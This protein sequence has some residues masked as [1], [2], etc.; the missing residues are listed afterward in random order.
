[1]RTILLVDDDKLHLLSLS[2]T[3]K[4]YYEKFNI[5]TAENG[6]EAERIL[7]SR[8]V[9]LLITDLNMPV[10]NG[11]ELLKFMVKKHS[12]I[13]VIVITASDDKSCR[14]VRSLSTNVKY[15]FS[16]PFDY[17]RLLELIDEHI[18]DVAKENIGKNYEQ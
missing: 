14:E 5:V 13:P 17:E 7:Q 9:D 1:M 12:P 6:E 3:L 15:C 16:K 8:H 18:N 11:F 10:K 2:E 4:L